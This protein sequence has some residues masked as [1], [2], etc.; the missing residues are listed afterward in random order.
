MRQ[1]SIKLI[2][3]QF[4][5]ISGRVTGLLSKFSSRE[6]KLLYSG[7]AVLLLV[8][9]IQIIKHTKNAFAEQALEIESAKVDLNTSIGLLNAYQKLR[10]RRDEIEKEYKKIE[11]K[12]GALSYL[13]SLVKEKLGGTVKYTIDPLAVQPF[14]LSFE[15]SPFAVK[16]T[17]QS[18]EKLVGLLKAVTT[19]ENPMFVTKL[20]MIRNLRGDGLDVNVELSCI[21]RA[22]LK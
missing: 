4:R 17:A 6:K 1:L 5:T 21:Q 8:L 9:S 20:D 10:V 19:G 22:G 14:G 2:T 3:D 7:I 12:E 15:Q 11:F 18:L 16:F 13:D